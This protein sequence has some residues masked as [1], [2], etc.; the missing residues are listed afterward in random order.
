M[1]T[2]R[3]SCNSSNLDS[4]HRTPWPSSSRLPHS[5]PRCRTLCCS[6]S[7]CKISQD[8]QPSLVQWAQASLTTLSRIYNEIVNH[9][10][11]ASSSWYRC[12]TSTSRIPTGQSSTSLNNKPVN[13][14]RRLTL[15]NQSRIM[16]FFSLWVPLGLKNKEQPIWRDQC[17]SRPA[18]RR[19]P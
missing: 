1:P 5:R 2:R 12:S 18:L 8:Q 7:S 15:F 14:P 9:K 11:L 6:S 19:H 3:T 16:H 10:L 4:S 13:L 17:L